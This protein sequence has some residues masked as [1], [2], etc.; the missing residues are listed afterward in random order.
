M[1]DRKGE[2]DNKKYRVK[3]SQIQSRKNIYKLMII[4]KILAVYSENHNICKSTVPV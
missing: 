1:S 3:T 4:K 2:I